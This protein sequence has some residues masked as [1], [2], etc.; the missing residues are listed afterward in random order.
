MTVNCAG[1]PGES[2]S[3]T[4]DLHVNPDDNRSYCKSCMR[5]R[6]ANNRGSKSE[7]SGGDSQNQDDSDE[8]QLPVQS[9][10]DV[11]FDPLLTYV[12]SSLS[13][14]TGDAA[15][16]AVLDR[17]TAAQ[18]DRARN[19]LWQ[20][21]DTTIIGVLVTRNS[22]TKRTAKVAQLADIFEAHQK[23]DRAKKLPA[24]AI[25]STDLH[26]IPRCHPEELLPVSAMDRMNRLEQRLTFVTDILDK[27][28]ADNAL[29][30]DQF[31]AFNRDTDDNDRPETG[32]TSS[33]KKKKKRNKKSRSQIPD[34]PGAA[35]LA[36]LPASRVSGMSIEHLES[37]DDSDSGEFTEVESKREIR[38][39]RT[40]KRQQQ[41]VVGTRTG[42]NSFKGAN[43]N[44]H[45]FVYGVSADATTE[46]IKEFIEKEHNVHLKHI[47]GLTPSARRMPGSTSQ[48]F[49]V[50]VS[51]EDHDLLSK[52]ESWPIG[53][54]VRRF[55]PARATPGDKNVSSI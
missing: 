33:R 25:L 6:R 13:S 26:L 11:I 39:R 37:S 24:V 1:K 16:N 30:R 51:C 5:A 9:P 10:I 18:I 36:G 19:A 40:Q 15:K 4:S 42:I 29:L 34:I 17:F 3:K 48:S 53:I 2:C 28:E 20:G 55:F 31:Q 54:K 50:T 44:R 35:T 7:T 41:H 45:L 43:P 47:E 32:E 8:P 52:P 22:S 12:W 14:G 49:H 23:L 27:V 46:D 21:A 38:Q